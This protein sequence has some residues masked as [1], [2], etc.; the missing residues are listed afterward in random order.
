MNPGGRPRSALR[1]LQSDAWKRR[2]YAIAKELGL[3]SY[4]AREAAGSIAR[5]RALLIAHGRDP[6][7]LGDVAERHPGGKPRT[8]PD[9]AARYRELRRRG[10]SAAAASRL[11]DKK[12]RYELTIKKLDKGIEVYE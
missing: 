7:A 5:F 6:Q 12:G 11:A 9:R 3:D 2:R 1:N 10:L 4:G 8:D